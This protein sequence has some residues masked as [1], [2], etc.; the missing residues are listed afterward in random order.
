LVA[1][2]ADTYGIRLYTRPVMTWHEFRALTHGVLAVE[3]RLWR[4]TKP[5][6]PENENTLTTGGLTFGE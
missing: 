2:F 1:D 6:E 3:S 5:P 4:A